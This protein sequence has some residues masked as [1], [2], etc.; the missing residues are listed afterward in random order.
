MKGVFSVRHMLPLTGTVGTLDEE[1]LQHVAEAIRA[2]YGMC[3]ECHT[4]G[5][6]FS[7]R[8][9]FAFSLCRNAFWPEVDGELTQADGRRVLRLRCQPV[10]TVRWFMLV[11]TLLAVV[12]QVGVL[13]SLEPDTLASLIPLL[14]IAFCFAMTHIGLRVFS[15]KIIR[16]IERAVGTA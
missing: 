6:A 7:L 12:M 5:A 2:A 8:P 14:L 3:Y 4:D 16:V 1:R 11:Y 9:Q 15:G 10:K 13:V